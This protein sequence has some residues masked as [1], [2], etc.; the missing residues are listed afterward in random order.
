MPVPKTE[1]EINESRKRREEIESQQ[2]S[3]YDLFEYETNK[4]KL[5]ELSNEQLKEIKDL[6]IKD[7]R[8][9]LARII[10]LEQ[11]KREL[12]LEN[13]PND[14]LRKLENQAINE[15]DFDLVSLIEDVIF[16]KIL[17]REKAMRN[18]FDQDEESWAQIWKLV[19]KLN[20]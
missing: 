20:E 5:Y 15:E 18:F 11:R 1:E 9:E 14:E 12:N 8:Y 4:E 10:K 13:L 3:S 7:K 16:W 17:K 19:E 2:N 6:A